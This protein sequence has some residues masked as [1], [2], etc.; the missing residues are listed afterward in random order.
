LNGLVLSSVSSLDLVVY[1]LL[2]DGQ[3]SYRAA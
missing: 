3:A 1:R 2:P